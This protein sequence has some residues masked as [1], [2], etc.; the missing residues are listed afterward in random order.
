MGCQLEIENFT[1][2]L[3]LLYKLIKENEIE[4]SK[5][6]LAKVTDQYLSYLDRL[7]DFNMD[8]ASEFTVIG[9]EL[10]Q[11]KAR[12]LL[13]IY[14]QDEEEEEPDLVA[15]LK[16]HQIIKELAGTLGELAQEAKAYHFPE[17]TIDMPEDNYILN[18]DADIKTVHRLYCQA[19]DAYESRLAQEAERKKLVQMAR[20]T[21]TLQEKINEVMTILAAAGRGQPLNFKELISDHQ[22]KLEIVITFLSIL[23]LN[24]LRKIKLEQS[25][26]FGEI[27]V[28]LNRRGG[29]NHESN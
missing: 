12:S 10:V 16:E 1:G 2:P 27:Q 28:E 6:S 5:I 20:Q 13:P 22:D 24:R 21:I 8:Q 17:R 23:E 25:R 26:R 9:A 4:I 18:L 11:L 29:Q 19:M 3:D 15:R 7:E 14:N